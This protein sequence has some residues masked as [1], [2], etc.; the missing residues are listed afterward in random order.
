MSAKASNISEYFAMHGEEVEFKTMLTSREEVAIFVSREDFD[1]YIG[2]SMTCC[3]CGEGPR[4]YTK[5]KLKRL[6]NK[7]YH[8]KCFKE[9]L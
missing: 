1:R 8:E 2:T 9:L 6:S 3:I 4:P 5:G 7:K